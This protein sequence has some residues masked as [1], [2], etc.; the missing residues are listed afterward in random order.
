LVRGIPSGGDPPQ[1]PRQLEHRH[2]HQHRHQRSP[3]ATDADSNAYAHTDA[4]TD[5]NAGPA[6]RSF[7]DQ[8]ALTAA[9]E[10][11]E[12][13]T[14]TIM[15]RSITRPAAPWTRLDGR[16]SM[17]RQRNELDEQSAAWRDNWPGRVLPRFAGLGRRRW[18]TASRS[19][20]H[21]FDKYE[22]HGRQARPCEQ[23]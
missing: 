16:S 17:D 6:G 19:K 5:S 1:H 2:R 8:P 23:R 10:T 3:D 15:S 20:Y 13:R 11:A 12:R 18:P 7:D 14:I 22:R 21:R 4:D 9:A